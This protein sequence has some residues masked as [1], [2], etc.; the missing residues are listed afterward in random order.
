MVVLRELEDP[1]RPLGVLL[2]GPDEELEPVLSWLHAR[3]LVDIV[4]DDHYELSGAGRQ[5][6]DRF[7]QRYEDFVRNMDVY[8]AVDLE[9]G[10]F[11]FERFFDFEDDIDFEDYL[12]GDQWDDLRVAVAEL[13]GID[14]IEWVFMSYLNEGRVGLHGSVPGSTLLRGPHWE[15][16][17]ELS[18]EAVAVEDLAFEE[19][20][21]T[22][23]GHDV[24]SQIVREGAELNLE[25]KRREIELDRQ[26]AEQEPQA[27]PAAEQETEVE[28]IETRYE[29]YLDPHYVPPFWMG[30]WYL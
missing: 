28:V 18:S 7:L 2:E 5:A 8:S 16:I 11:A 22:V 12:E 6:V 14:P 10:A 30:G 27:A 23:S 20:G 17:A 9:E 1:D 25:L 3:G 24:L 21:D 4:G 26:R 13:K 15:E 29:P 19:D